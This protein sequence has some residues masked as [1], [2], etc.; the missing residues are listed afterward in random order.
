MKQLSDIDSAAERLNLASYH[1]PYLKQFLVEYNAAGKDI[2]EVG[3]AMPPQ[4]VIDIIGVNSWTST[5]A[6]SYACEPGITNQ[7]TA[8]QGLTEYQG[9][10]NTILTN[11]EE[12]SSDQYGRYD[13]I[14][15][16]A[17][18]E[19]IAKLPAALSQ[20]RRLLKPNGEGKIFSMFSP[21]WS[22]HDGHH[23]YHLEVP[24]RLH[25]VQSQILLPWE[26]LLNDRVSLYKALLQRFDRDFAEEVIYN[27]Y[28]SPHINRYFH[29][30][31]D[32][33]IRNS[34]F[35]LIKFFPTF[36]VSVPAEVQ[37]KLERRHP[38]HRRFDNM[39]FYLLAET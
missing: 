22:C 24:S 20:M 4:I 37:A 33:F 13:A 31:F 7:Y 9:Q 23:L 10:Y 17:C 29:E 39:G 38:G 30:D 35:K 21:I 18:F 19:H 5:E 16:I 34:G 32:Y 6:P 27:V 2:L 3:G 1:A 14:F 11:I 26:H 15:S 25:G 28:N 36:C 12:F 8:N